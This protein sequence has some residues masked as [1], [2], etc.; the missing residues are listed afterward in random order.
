MVMTKDK[1]KKDKTNADD[2]KGLDMSYCLPARDYPTLQDAAYQDFSQ[3]GSEG[4]T[5]RIYLDCL[6]NPTVGVGHLIMPK[7]GLGNKKT[8]EVYRQKYLS[9]D[10]KV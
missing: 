10:L 5:H 6:G 3:N 1:M 2:L 9:L 7:K 4:K 8:E